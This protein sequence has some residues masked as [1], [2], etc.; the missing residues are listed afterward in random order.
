MLKAESFC[1]HT[2]LIRSFTISSFASRILAG[3]GANF[4][5]KVWVV[6][7]QIVSIPVLSSQ[8]GA[9]VYGVWI[10]IS[11]IPTYV[12]LSAAGF[13]AAAATDMTSRV[14]AG[15]LKGA[16][17]TFQ[18][19]WLLITA[20]TGTICLFGFALWALIAVFDVALLRTEHGEVINSIILL[21]IYAFFVIQSAVVQ[22]IYRSTLRYA[23]G[24]LILDATS[25]V[26]GLAVVFV[27]S[28]GK[29]I[30][31]AA[32]TLVAIRCVSIVMSYKWIQRQEQW[33]SYGVSSA[34]LA[35]VRRLAHPAM[36]ALT[37]TA[38][39]ALALQGVVA[40]I[41]LV[42]SPAAAAAFATA[43]TIARLPLQISDILGRATVPEMTRAH[44]LSQPAIFSRLTL[45]NMGVAAAVLLPSCALISWLGRDI[46][47]IL[48][49][50]NLEY[51]PYLFPSLAFAAA[52]QGLWLAAAQ[53]LVA[54]NRQHTFG[55]VYLILAAVMA[56]SPWALQYISEPSTFVAMTTAA[57]E[58]LTLV[59][60]L[61]VTRS[62]VYSHPQQIQ[63]K[64]TS[65]D[66]MT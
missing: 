24:T 10:M 18:S 42:A 49:G 22:A 28:A 50:G 62:A 29:G 53:S 12:N 48:G 44:A 55:Y 14:S 26:E 66:E 33:V 63:I 27:A 30:E 60:V 6:L 25:L 17:A 1:E 46:G 56:A 59:F 11:T 15:D 61:S 2:L 9:S 3:V 34:D 41:G 37:L 4:V 57:L 39:N 21:V 47:V 58:M 8:W 32:L 23:T 64:R 52:F 45:V 38:A 16:V 51:P 43:R 31:I 54:I 65:G 7:I 35:I 40:G 36:G 5:G 19:V 20:V 13:G